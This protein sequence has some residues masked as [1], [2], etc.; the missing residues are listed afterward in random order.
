MDGGFKVALDA[1]GQ[2]LGIVIG[3][4][5][6]GG[7][8]LVCR[9]ARQNDR[10][11]ARTQRVGKRRKVN[12]LVIAAADGHDGDLGGK[13]RQCRTRSGGRRVDRAVVVGHAAKRAHDLESMLH[14]AKRRSD[15]SD[16]LGGDEIVDKAEGGHVVFNII[17][18]GQ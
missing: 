9:R 15:R 16:G 10:V 3:A 13:G 18:T 5:V 11:H 4:G 6:D 2:A 14:A 1:N 17:L 8:D 7:Q 12:V